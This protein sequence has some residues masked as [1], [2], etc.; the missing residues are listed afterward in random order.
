MHWSFSWRALRWLMAAGRQ[1]QDHALPA[2]SD[3]PGARALAGCVP[4]TINFEG[5]KSGFRRARWKAGCRRW[6]SRQAPQLR[7]DPSATRSA[8]GS[9]AR[10][11]GHHTSVKTTDRYAHVMMA[12]KRAALEK[13][14]LFTPGFT[15]GRKSAPAGA[16]KCL[17]LL[18]GGAGF[19]PATP[20]V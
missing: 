9:G 7:N 8:D 11:A 1:H 19:E 10:N 2:G 14:G 16:A 3:L 18:V 6:I 5:V 13:L 4:P 20:A 12:P 17:F 15:P